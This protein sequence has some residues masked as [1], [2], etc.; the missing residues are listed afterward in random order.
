MQKLFDKWTR[1]YPV[2]TKRALEI[3][4]GLV[5]WTLILFPIFGSLL[6]PKLV[7]Y[8][9]IT[10]AVYWFYR[11]FSVA[12]LALIGHFR[13]QASEKYDWLGDLKDF[14]GWKKVQHVILMP[15]YREPITIL[16]RSLEGLRKQTVPLANLHVYVSFEE[17]EGEKAKEK[18]RELRKEFRGVFG[19]LVTTFH[20]DIEGEVKGKSANTSWAAKSAKKKL[21]DEEGG[22][23][24]RM[25]VTSADADSILHH[26]YFANLTYQFLDHPNRYQRI[27]QPAVVFYN[28]IWEVPAPIRVLASVWSVVHVYVLMRKDVLINFSTYSTSM[29]MIS[30]IHL[31]RI[32]KSLLVLQINL[33]LL[34]HPI[35]NILSQ[36]QSGMR[37]QSREG[38]EEEAQNRQQ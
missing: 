35:L 33:N 8:Y 6:V 28:N 1:R 3:L 5:S 24:S 32:S 4:P 36:H 25:T 34:C 17:R 12:I 21:V 30:D 15:T 23:I 20:P 13:L 29:K 26:N 37:I 10:F 38:I 22:D 31:S 19:T 27:W 18:A 14:P 2:K 7:A 11:S 9:I 16:K